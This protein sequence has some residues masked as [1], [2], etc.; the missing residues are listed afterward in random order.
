VREHDRLLLAREI[1]RKNRNPFRM[2]G[3]IDAASKDLELMSRESR[4]R[5]KSNMDGSGSRA[6]FLAVVPGP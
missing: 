5:W 3:K 4:I 6:A 2:S 1:C